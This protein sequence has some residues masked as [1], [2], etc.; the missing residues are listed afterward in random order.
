MIRRP[1]RSTLFPYTT[2]FRSQI[3][4]GHRFSIQF[5]Y[6]H[7]NHFF[8]DPLR[9]A[10]LDRASS[11]WADQIGDDFPTLPQGSLLRIPDPSSVSGQLLPDFGSPRP[12]VTVSIFLGEAS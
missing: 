6:N 11:Y 4:V 8:D 5:D 3:T 12:I 9:R 7:S 1:P 10:L 2:L